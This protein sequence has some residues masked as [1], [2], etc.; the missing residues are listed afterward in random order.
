MPG[1]E[2]LHFEDFAVGESR[3]FG[4]YV[5]TAKEIKDF[6]QEFDPQSFHLDEEAGKKSILGGLCASGWHT[7][8]MLMRMMVDGYLGRSAS[9]GSPGLDEL[10]WLKPVFP[11]EILNA[12]YTVLSKRRSSKKPDMGIV[13]MRWEVFSAHGEKKMEV[14]GVN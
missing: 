2:L 5:V 3:D 7:G 13:T 4:R 11:G 12:L 9:L 6:A 10:K 14:A 1:N 8:A